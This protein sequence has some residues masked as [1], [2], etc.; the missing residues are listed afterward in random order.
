[1]ERTVGEWMT[2]RSLPRSQLVLVGKVRGSLSAKISWRQ[3]RVFMFCDASYVVCFV[4]QVLVVVLM[5]PMVRV[6]VPHESSEQTPV[7]QIKK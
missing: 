3:S 5:I 7:T 6:K 2:Q 4:T 1:M